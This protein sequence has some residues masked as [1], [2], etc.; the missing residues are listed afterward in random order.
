MEWTIL[1][2]SLKVI[3]ANYLFVL[4]FQKLYVSALVNVELLGVVLEEKR[5]EVILVVVA[6]VE[7]TLG[8]VPSRGVGGHDVVGKHLKHVITQLSH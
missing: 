6:E 8:H 5:Q 4:Q 3:N 2:T 7:A 1:D